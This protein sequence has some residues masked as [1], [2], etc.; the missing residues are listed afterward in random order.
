ME[1]QPTYAVIP[2]GHWILCDDCYIK[3]SENNNNKC[4]LCRQHI[5]KYQKIYL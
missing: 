4:C 1:N 2:C 5:D 3:L